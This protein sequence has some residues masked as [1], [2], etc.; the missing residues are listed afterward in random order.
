LGTFTNKKRPKGEKSPNLV[1]QLWWTVLRLTKSKSSKIWSVKS[2]TNILFSICFFFLFFHSFF[3]AET[4]VSIQE[5]KASSTKQWT[6]HHSQGSR[7]KRAMHVFQIPGTG[8]IIFQI[9]STKNL[10]KILAFFAQ[11]T[12]SF[13]KNCDHNI[14]F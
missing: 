8:V 11:A 10:A 9:F 14:G 3:S 4:Q 13:C 12:A 2:A 1:T 6:Y 5:K 7:K